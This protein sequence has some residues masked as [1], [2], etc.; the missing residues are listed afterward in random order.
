MLCEGYDEEIGLQFGRSFADSPDID[1]IV[2]F[3]GECAAGEFAEVE[4]NEIAD[5]EWYGRQV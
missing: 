2:F 3:S 4:I 5:G 1:G